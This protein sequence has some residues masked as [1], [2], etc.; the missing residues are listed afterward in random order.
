MVGIR[1]LHIHGNEVQTLVVGK[2]GVEWEE[3]ETRMSV[4]VEPLAPLSLSN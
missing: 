4:P 2:I 1:V 3:W